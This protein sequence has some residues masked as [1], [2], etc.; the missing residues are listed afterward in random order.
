MTESITHTWW[1]EESSSSERCETGTT[2]W[3]IEFSLRG[4]SWL[5][6]CG[7][8]L[9][10][11]LIRTS[12]TSFRPNGDRELLPEGL[13]CRA[14]APSHLS[15][16]SALSGRRACRAEAGVVPNVVSVWVGSVLA[17]RKNWNVRP[18]SSI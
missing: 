2:A 16:T 9:G 3:S 10:A 1:A 11:F 7:L 13:S 15:E 17:I 8:S 5:S 18:L 4:L 14:S 6:F 12:S